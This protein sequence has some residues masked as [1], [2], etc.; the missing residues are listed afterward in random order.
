MDTQG[1]IPVKYRRRTAKRN[2]EWDE[3]KE[4]VT[5]LHRIHHESLQALIRKRI[6]M[7]VSQDRADVICHF[8]WN[9]FKNIESNRYIPT[10]KQCERIQYVFHVT[11]QI[12][13]VT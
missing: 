5:L 10:D 2:D 8:P 9:T 4:T 6:Q 13:L 11:L 1:W 7:R 3:K 12:V